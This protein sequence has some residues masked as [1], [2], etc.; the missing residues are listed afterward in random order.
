MRAATSAHYAS[1]TPLTTAGDYGAAGT[2]GG[3]E[4]TPL[5]VARSGASYVVHCPAGRKKTPEINILAASL[6]LF[7]ASSHA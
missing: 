5:T 6:I 3:Y 1:S 7:N 4:A 2:P